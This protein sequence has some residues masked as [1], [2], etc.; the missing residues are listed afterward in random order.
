MKPPGTGDIAVQKRSRQPVST[1]DKLAVD[2]VAIGQHLFGSSFRRSGRTSPMETTETP[3]NRE[4]FM[5]NAPAEG[6]STPTAAQP[7]ARP[8]S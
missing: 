3:K 1:K 8:I 5:R 6:R 2:A 7:A 4:A